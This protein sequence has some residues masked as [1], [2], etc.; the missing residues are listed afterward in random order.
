M[1]VGAA[2]VLV[3][4]AAVL[5]A[6]ATGGAGGHYTELNHSKCWSGHGGI[7]NVDQSLNQ[8]IVKM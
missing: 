2:L 3:M 5:L 7:N 4:M 6:P 8:I 1:P